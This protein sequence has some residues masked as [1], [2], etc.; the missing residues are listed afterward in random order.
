MRN[1][2]PNRLN[3]TRAI[4]DKPFKNGCLSAYDLIED[5]KVSSSPDAGAAQTWPN[6]PRM[7]SSSAGIEALGSAT[8]FLKRK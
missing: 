4:A 1:F 5:R 7:R 8:A 3:D 6:F 2:N